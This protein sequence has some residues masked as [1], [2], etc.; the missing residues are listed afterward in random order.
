MQ[1]PALSTVP[2]QSVSTL[3]ASFVPFALISPHR[4]AAAFSRMPEVD[5]L[6]ITRADNSDDE[7]GDEYE[8]WWKRED[9]YG[10]PLPQPM[11]HGSTTVI[12]VKGVITSGYPT[13]YRAIGFA[14]ADE[15]A[16]W[17][18]AAM[19]DPDVAQIVL[20]VDSPGGMC[21]GTPEL[22]DT[23]AAAALVKPV[24]AH[25]KGLMDSAAYWV[26]S[27][28]TAIYCTQSADIGCIGVYQVNYDWSGWNEKV[29][30]RAEMFKSGDLKGAGHP[31]VPLSADQ[32]AHIQSQID[33]IGAQFRAA[34]TTK[35]TLVAEDSMRGQSFIGTEA[36]T[37]NLVAGLCSLDDLLR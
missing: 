21:N 35:R 34:V 36:V 16:G 25:S 32:R 5:F 18:R 31:D 15:I 24:I 27:Q 2:C 10:D 23:V 3:L 7:D 8:P 19:A 29:G 1:H 30:V 12:P 6:A 14:D 9:I 4:L 17:V 22:A 13:I 20:S 28:A 37:R 33:A 26:A 11:R